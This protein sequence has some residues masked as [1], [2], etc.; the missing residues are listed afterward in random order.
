[1]SWKRSSRRDKE[2]EADQEGAGGW[3]RSAPAVQ[4]P[5]RHQEPWIAYRRRSSWWTRTRNGSPSPRRTSSRYRSSPSWIRIAT[6]SRS[7]FRSRATTTRS[8]QSGCSPRALPT[9]SSSRG[10]SGRPRA[11]S[12]EPRRSQVGRRQSERRRSRAGAGGSTRACAQQA[13]RTRRPGRRA[14]PEG[15]RIAGEAGAGRR[16]QDRL[17]GL[18][19]PLAFRSQLRS[20]AARGP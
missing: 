15:I 12:S 16:R 20:T 7:T 14:T 18:S 4:E 13:H 3:R 17:D 9:R 6:R 8:V 19:V 1:M 2:D 5:V 11:R 10:P